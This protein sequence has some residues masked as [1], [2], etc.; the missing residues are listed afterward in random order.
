MHPPPL[1]PF[2]FWFFPGSEE[3]P[4][5]MTKNYATA[6]LHVLIACSATKC[7]SKDLYPLGCRKLNECACI[8]FVSV[9]C[10]CLSLI[11]HV[12]GG[13]RFSEL[14]G[15]DVRWMPW[16]IAFFLLRRSFDTRLDVPVIYVRACSVVILSSYY[17]GFLRKKN[18]YHVKDHE[19]NSLIRYPSAVSTTVP[20]Q[21]ICH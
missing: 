8:T 11:I 17:L 1:L 2:L 14:C 12:R 20:I 18:T 10:D 7:V 4:V 16:P 6:L 21:R 3:I 13:Y 9:F 15:C 5:N 19:R